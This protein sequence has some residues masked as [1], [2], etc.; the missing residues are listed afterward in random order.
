MR[1][2]LRALFAAAFFASFVGASCGQSYLSLMPGVINDPGNLSLR[3]SILAFGISHM[4]AEAQKR[5]VPLKLRTEDPVLGRFRTTTCFSQGLANN[6]V[7]VQFGGSGY[8][9]TNLTQRMSFDAAGAVEYDVDFLMSGA[10][11]YVYFREKS[12]S[13]ATFTPKLIEQPAAATVSGL[14]LGA[15]GQSLAVS[16]GQQIMANEIARGFTVIR[17]AD[18]SVQFSL[19]VVEKGTRPVDASPYTALSGNVQANERT[20]VHQNQRDFAGPFEVPDGKSLSIT[21]SIE[22]APAIDIIVMPRALGEAWLQTYTT[23][24]QTTPPPA[25]PVLDEPAYAGPLWR[26]KLSVPEGLYYVVFDNT[27]TAGRTAPTGYGKDDRA[28]LVSYAVTVE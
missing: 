25:P 3:R 5:S 13:A 26:R 1:R 8:A 16:F 20:E 14:P 18:G 28:A 15:N 7:F 22:G 24:A 4:C 10:T 17:D 11:M 23:Q 19:G 9:W 6:N 21:A 27:A 2:L 12:T